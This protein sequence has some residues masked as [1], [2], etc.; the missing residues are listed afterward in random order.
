M[1]SNSEQLLNATD[2][3]PITFVVILPPNPR[4]KNSINS[5]IYLG[6]SDENTKSKACIIKILLDSGASASIVQKDVLH[7]HLRFLKD[8]KNKWSIMAWTFNTTFV[9]ELKL[10]L[11]EINHTLEIYVNYHWTNKLLSYDLILGRDIL[12]EYGIIFS[13][14][15]KTITRQKVS[16]SMK[17]PNCM[18]NKFFVIKENRTVRNATKRI[19]QILDT[20]YKTNISQNYSYEFQLF[21]KQT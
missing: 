16:I 12:H 20:V 18:A 19:K 11:P 1:K 21:K 14:N 10:K 17:L 3:L 7:K 8:K 4:G 5:Q 6:P 9:T 13:I 15:N 2:L